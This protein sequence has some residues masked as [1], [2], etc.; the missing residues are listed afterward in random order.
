MR[1][2]SKVLLSESGDRYIELHDEPVL[3]YHINGDCETEIPVLE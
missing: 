3:R 1:V 2:G